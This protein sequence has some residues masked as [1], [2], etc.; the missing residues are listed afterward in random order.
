MQAL[1]ARRIEQLRPLQ[2]AT[3]HSGLGIVLA[4]GWHAGRTLPQP[5]W[6]CRHAATS[7]PAARAR[8]SGGW[9]STVR[10][11]CRGAWLEACMDAAFF[12]S[13]RVALHRKEPPTASSCSPTTSGANSRWPLPRRRTN[14]KRSAPW[15][16]RSYAPTCAATHQKER[17]L[18]RCP[19]CAAAVQRIA[20]GHRPEANRGFGIGRAS[21]RYAVAVAV[22]L[23]KSNP[24]L[25]A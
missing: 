25:P 13:Q 9:R 14:A 21:S 10:R 1:P 12:D 22:A 19:V 17:V 2:L 7:R 24:A 6:R 5:S 20:Q 18:L 23:F 16:L 11:P 3:R 8:G 15:A 4:T